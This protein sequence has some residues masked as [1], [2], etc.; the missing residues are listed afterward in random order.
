MSIRE[1]INNSKTT[2]ISIVA[3]CL[4]LAV[5]FRFTFSQKQI[6]ASEF[7]YFF[8]LNTGDLV[9]E[10]AET[11]S[12]IKVNGKDSRVLAHVISCTKC[13]DEDSLKTAYVT[14][15]SDKALAI[16]E[17]GPAN[18]GEAEFVGSGKGALVSTPEKAQQDE[19]SPQ[20]SPSGFT[21]FMKV[22]KLCDDVEPTTCFPS[23]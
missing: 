4:L 20:H 22:N 7:V 9:A 19:W 15:L 6:Q 21:V 14:K 18:P 11:N 16:A 10:S 17:K 2:S 13:K 8:D 23:L 1:K 5:L 3:I 12:P